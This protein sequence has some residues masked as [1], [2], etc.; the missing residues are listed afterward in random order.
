MIL[1]IIA[2]AAV[3]CIICWGVEGWDFFSGWCFG[4][5]VS[6]AILVLCLIIMLCMYAEV[7][8]LLASN[9]QIYE[10]LTYQIENHTYDEGIGKVEL[11]KQVTEWNKDLA[12]GR[13]DQSNFWYGIFVP[14]IYDEFEFIPLDSIK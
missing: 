8:G 3:I 7:P 10:S 1:A 11:M 12:R 4:T 6:V 9:Q 2:L 13:E 5:V 14:N